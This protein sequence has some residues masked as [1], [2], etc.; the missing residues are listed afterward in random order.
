MKTKSFY[1]LIITLLLL[2]GASSLKAQQSLLYE[3]FNSSTSLPTTWDNTETSTT[4]WKIEKTNG[5]EGY[6]AYFNSYSAAAGN[7][8]VFKTPLLTFTSDKMFSFVFKNAKGGDFSIYVD[9]YEADGVNYTRHLLE[10]GLKADDWTTKTYSLKDYTNKNIRIS[11]SG[12]SNKAKDLGVANKY[13]GYILLDKVVVEDVS[14]CAYPTKIELVSVLQNSASV[15]WQLDAEGGS[16]PTNFRLTLTD[17]QGA[18]V[19]DYNDYLFENDGSYFFTLEGLSSNSVY[20]LK[21]RSDCSEDSKG[22]S[23]W[24][25]E[26]EFST[27]CEPATLPFVEDFNADSRVLSSC[28]MVGAD[29]PSGVSISLSGFQSPSLLR[30]Y[31]PKSLSMM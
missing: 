18:V 19:G 15:Q 20:K 3:D 4:V 10:S 13:E 7:S 11:F 28:W 12:T 14:I 21:L 24:S 27:L 5:Y 30:Q 25:D 2:L 16:V 6:S 22:I 26:F 8:S 9:E 17:S 29:N 23:K 31:V 1:S